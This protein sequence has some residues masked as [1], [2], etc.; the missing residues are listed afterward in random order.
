MLF[1]SSHELLNIKGM[2]KNRIEIIKNTLISKQSETI[3]L[4]LKK[5][6]FDIKNIKKIYK[7]FENET[8]DILKS[9]PYVLIDKISG[10]GFNICD[11]LAS[12]FRM[13]INNEFR[14]NSAIIYL[15]KIN[16]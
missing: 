5:G 16:Y 12:E 1:Y 13:D 2:T 8:I 7:V 14:I 11:K 3:F 6:G 10:I 9:N 4:F 15:F